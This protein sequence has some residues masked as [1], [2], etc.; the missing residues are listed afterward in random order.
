M[1]QLFVLFESSAGY[2]LFE[3]VSM[4]E[5]GAQEGGIQEAMADLARFG[6][7]VKLVSFL[8]FESAKDALDA[9]NAISEGIAT[10]SLQNWLT[11]HLPAVRLSSSLCVCVW[12]GGGRVVV[13]AQSLLLWL[14]D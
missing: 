6:K 4:E 1:S 8:A 7:M 2:G 10:D 13:V 11:N 9:I 14:T 12:G 5:I 3:R